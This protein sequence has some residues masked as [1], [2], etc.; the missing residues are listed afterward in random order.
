MM[1]QYPNIPVLGPVVVILVLATVLLQS[2]CGSDTLGVQEL[3]WPVVCGTGHLA[4]GFA[5]GLQ[6]VAGKEHVHLLEC[7]VK[8][9]C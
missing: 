5:Q 2:R 9:A 7:R 6:L 8:L 1:R 3:G 4:N